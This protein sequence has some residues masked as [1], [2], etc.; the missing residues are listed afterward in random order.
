LCSLETSYLK[1]TKIDQIIYDDF[2]KEF[3]DLNVKNLDVDQLK[4][5]ESKEVFIEKIKQKKII[6]KVILRN[7]VH[8][9]KATEI[10]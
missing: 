6:I 4:S 8:F 5:K 1:L 2:R 9:A 3:P 10:K 7:G